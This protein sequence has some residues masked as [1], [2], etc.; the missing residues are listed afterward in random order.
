VN[1]ID[2]VLFQCRQGPAAPAICAPGTALNVVSYGRLE[3]FIHNIGRRA[4]A[5]GLKRGDVVAIFMAD[6]IFHAALVLGLTALG[7]VTL[8]GRSTELPKEF[9][10]DAVISDG[11]Q[12]FHS[13][14]RVIAADP[15]WLAGDGVPIERPPVAPDD[16]CR[17][18]LTS[19]TTG[20]AKGIMLT[21]RMVHRRLAL[22]A[23]A[24]GAALP[25][26]TRIFCDLGLTTSLGFMFLMHAL[27][28]GGTLFLRGSDAG[29]TIQAFGLYQVQALV[30]SPGGL[31]E[32]LSYY[33]QTPNFSSAFEVVVS[34]GSL[35]SRELARRVRARMCS[36][37]VSAYG[38]T[39]ASIVAAAPAPIIADAEG[40]VGYPLP[41]V[42]VEAAGPNDERLPAGERGLIRIRSENAASG[43]HGSPG[44]SAFRNGWF[45]PGDIGAVMPDGRLV[46]GGRDTTVLNLGGEKISS[47]RIEA[48]LASCPGVAE[49]AVVGAVNALGVEE[50]H[51]AI[52][53]NGA[54]DEAAAR[55][56][57]A[58]SLA[59]ECVPTRFVQLAALPRND[60]GKLDRRRLRLAVEQ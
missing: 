15:S 9:A 4:L 14:Q 53:A 22:H 3:R 1:I 2:P 59:L 34:G 16:P 44:A 17:I 33:E 36:N 12:R 27:Q 51:A 49:A 32:F 30:A 38:S 42:S 10:I 8:T 31:A 48:V 37:L 46:I 50:V 55:H 18:V 5:H 57:C 58:R 60:M 29:E 11:L 25:A 39:E 35:L 26:C 47:E 13:G 56:H 23:Y 7:I 45:Y 28:R 43:Y 21:H 24:F 6:P 20:E 52:V 40:A 41:G 19:G 54:F